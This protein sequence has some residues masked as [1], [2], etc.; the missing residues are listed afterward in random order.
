MLL[1]KFV[2]SCDVHG[3]MEILCMRFIL[4]LKKK[5]VLIFFSLAAGI[6]VVCVGVF[7]A[8]ATVLSWAV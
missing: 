7:L 3:F 6:F 8:A 2:C 1:E 5:E 4:F